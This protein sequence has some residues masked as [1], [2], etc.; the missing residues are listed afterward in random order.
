M[1]PHFQ[2]GH[3]VTAFLAIAGIVAACAPLHGYPDDPEDT[4]AT[5][6]ALAPYF[7]P[8]VDKTYNAMPADVP[9]GTLN[10]QNYR[11]LVVMSRMRAYDLEFDSFERRLNGDS[12]VVA[13]GGD[14]TLLVLGAL[15]AT[16]G[17]AT[18]KA[19][20]GA[21]STA[22]AGAQTAVNKDLYFQKTLPAMLD[23]MEA[24]RAKAK[25]PIFQGLTLPDSQYPLVRAEIDLQILKQS[26][27]I[28]SA[29]SVI[30]KMTSKD[31]QDAQAKLAPLRSLRFSTSSTSQRIMAW[32]LPGGKV[33]SSNMARLQQWMKQDTEDPRLQDM[34]P[35]Q[36][37][38]ENE[39][40]EA[41]R[42]RA[43]TA[44]HIP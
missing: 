6:A 42:A 21:A 24:N 4:T 15:T 44:L 13:L 36:L 7:D 17:S 27:S 8:A 2:T 32:L 1:P 18:T 26:G 38:N 9:P 28:P 33:D 31:N 19:A 16:L 25:L 12:N 20:L 34:P 29:I 14:V 11:D 37:L 22:V 41:D 39:D 3:I 23:Q 5:L 35:M 40:L 43:I 10:R 30:T